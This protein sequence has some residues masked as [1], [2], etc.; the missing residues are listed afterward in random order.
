MGL[1]L[2]FVSTAT[3]AASAKGWRTKKAGK[4][5]HA[6]LRDRAV[7]ELPLA[8]I[9]G[10]HKGGL[11]GNGADGHAAADDFAVGA[12]IRID[13]VITLGA[14]GVNAKTGDHLVKNKRYVVL[15]AEGAGFLQEGLGL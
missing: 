7:A 2:I 12:N 5:G 11:A 10:I 13:A 3:A 8:A 1:V 4:V 15:G 14:P 9:K 6:H